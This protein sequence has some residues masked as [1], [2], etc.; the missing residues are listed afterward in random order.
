MDM[1]FPVSIFQVYK[2]LPLPAYFV[3][4]FTIAA[5][6]VDALLPLHKLVLCLEWLPTWSLLD[7]EVCCKELRQGSFTKWAI[8]L[9]RTMV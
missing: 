6:A 5:M 9:G 8:T 1:N 7:A 4:V 2:C 3:Y